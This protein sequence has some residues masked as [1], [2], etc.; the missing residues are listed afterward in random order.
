MKYKIRFPAGYQPRDIYNDNMDMN[1]FLPD[2]SI[3][4]GTAFTVLNI[5]NLMEKENESWFWST[6]MFIVRDV[7][8]AGP[9]F[10][11]PVQY[12]GLPCLRSGHLFL[13]VQCCG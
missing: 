13:L 9:R 12:P 4:F 7:L 8:K 5:D 6:D 11:F 10:P 2:G 1:I 3:Y